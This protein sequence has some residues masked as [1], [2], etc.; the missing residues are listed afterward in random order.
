MNHDHVPTREFT[1]SDTPT[2]SAPV[3]ATATPI[4]P[5]I[6]P[7]GRLMSLDALRGFTMFWILGVDEAI[8]S[9]AEVNNSAVVGAIKTQLTHV[10]WE[11]FVFEDLIFPMFVFIV[12]VSIVFSLGKLIANEGRHAAVKRVLLRS[13]VLYILGL[14]YYYDCTDELFH[15]IRW[16]GVLQRIALC[17]LL[18]RASLLL[19]STPWSGGRLSVCAS[20][21]LGA[22][23]FRSRARD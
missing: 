1:M 3:E 7:A 19:P 9:L 14:V 10:E 12:G 13:L 2:C 20:G 6:Y 11:G 22:H 18:C 4:D 16:L 21:V 5:P 23:E 15:Q 17:Y 8:H